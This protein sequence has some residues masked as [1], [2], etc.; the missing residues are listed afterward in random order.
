MN[1]SNLK[2]NSTNIVGWLFSLLLNKTF[3]ASIHKFEIP[4]F[5]RVRLPGINSFP[6]NLIHEL[7]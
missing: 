2:R 4:E 6:E 5:P 1:F 3:G 7:K